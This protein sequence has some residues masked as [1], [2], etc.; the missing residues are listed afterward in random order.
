MTRRPL[1]AA[2]M[3]LAA[4]GCAPHLPGTATTTSPP[5]SAAPTEAP[6]TAPPPSLVFEVPT[7]TGGEGDIGTKTFPGNVTSAGLPVGDPH[8][9]MPKPGTCHLGVR[10]GQPIPD[11][12]CTPGAI[13]PAVTQATIGQTICVSGWTKTVRPPTS[14]TGPMKKASAASYDLPPG[15]SEYDHLVALSLGGAPSDPRNLWVEPGSI[16]NRKDA[17]EGLLK[18]EVCAGRMTLATAQAGIASDW[19]Q[20]LGAGGAPADEEN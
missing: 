15:A 2:L 14:V 12:A 11:P 17:V 16:P 1:L 19:T 7:T 3:A 18:R 5:A 10:N 20:Y 8:A 6:T 13:N 4:A 9:P